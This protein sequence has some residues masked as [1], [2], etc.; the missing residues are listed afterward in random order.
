M[1]RQFHFQPSGYLAI[2]LLLAHSA[3]LLAIYAIPLPGW[4][5][6]ALTLLLLA[7]LLF[8]LR[9]DAQLSAP[10]SVI[11]LTL[12]GDDLMLTARNGKCWVARLLSTSMV[13]PVLTVLNSSSPGAI[14]ARPI[15]IFPDS[16][17]AE[18]FR[19]LRVWLKWRS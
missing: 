12:D 13:T 15:I 5:K 7:N 4:A 16:L 9:R 17:D 6:I 10:S 14:F 18:S 1:P 19:Q 8:Y 2:S 3:A 11:T